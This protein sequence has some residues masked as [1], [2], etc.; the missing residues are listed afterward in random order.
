MR[1]LNS[2]YTI[3]LGFIV[4]IISVV[5]LNNALSHIKNIEKMLELITIYTGTNTDNLSKYSREIMYAIQLFGLY[6]GVLGIFKARMT[7]FFALLY[8]SFVFA[9][10]YLSFIS[11][12][13]NNKI[14]FEGLLNLSL[15]GGVLSIN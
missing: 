11:K 14:L 10:F 7:K 4:T 3:L 13:I 8:F 15:F 5:S 2:F 6:S 1:I 9:E 12:D